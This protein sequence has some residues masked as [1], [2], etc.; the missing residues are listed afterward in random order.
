MRN[1]SYNYDTF[2]N[3]ICNVRDPENNRSFDVSG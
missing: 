3:K 1:Y 2:V